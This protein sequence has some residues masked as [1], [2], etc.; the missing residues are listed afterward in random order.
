MITDTFP[1]YYSEEDASGLYI[2]RVAE[3]AEAA[4]SANYNPANQDNLTIAAFGIDVQNCFTHPDGSLFVSGAI[5]D[6]RRSLSWLYRNMSRIS[7]LLFSL[8][9]HSEHQIFHPAYW[10]NEQG[11]HPDAFTVISTEDV[12][13]KKWQPINQLARALEYVQELERFGKNALTIWPYHAL[14]GSSGAALQ[15][16]VREAAMFHSL[17]RQVDTVFKAKG[18]QPETEN[19]SVLQPE[20]LELEGEIIGSFNEQF[21]Q[22]LMAHDR[23]YVFGQAK[24]HCVLSTLLD[25]KIRMQQENQPL[26]KIYILEDCMSPVAPPPLEPLPPELDFPSV[27]DAAIAELGQAGMQVVRSTDELE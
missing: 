7:T 10:T 21:Y 20:V 4:R 15:S 17:T 24:S 11:L 16:A 25:L 9:T 26:S 2:E 8:D 19:F 27:A 5:E 23:V 13:S 6:T 22:Q 14:E 1:S 18:R 12:R 3:V